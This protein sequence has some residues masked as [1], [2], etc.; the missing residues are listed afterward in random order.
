MLVYDTFLFTSA[1]I[2]RGG[3]LSQPARQQELALAAN[4]EQAR[5]KRENNNPNSLVFFK[6]VFLPS[7]TGFYGDE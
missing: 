1:E 4:V 3:D 7:Q 2:H 5:S 6:N